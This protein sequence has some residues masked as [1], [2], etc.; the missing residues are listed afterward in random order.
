[1]DNPVQV[2]RSTG[3]YRLLQSNC[4]AVQQKTLNH[5]IDCNF[6][7]IGILNCYAVRG[8]L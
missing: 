3:S 4:V 5:E 6:G 2:K 8:D 7:S 1:M